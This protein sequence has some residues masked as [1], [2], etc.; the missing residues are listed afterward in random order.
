M[1]E[2]KIHF[3]KMMGREQEVDPEEHADDVIQRM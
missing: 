2:E 3:R 1:G